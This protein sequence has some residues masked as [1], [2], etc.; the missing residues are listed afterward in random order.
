TP[1]PAA[2]AGPGRRRRGRALLAAATAAALALGL[3]AYL[4]LGP[5][6]DGGNRERRTA[7]PSGTARW[8]SPPEGWRPWQ[9]TLRAPAARGVVKAR[10]FGL[11]GAGAAAQCLPSGGAVYCG[12]EAALPVRLDASTGATDWRADL[13][14]PGTAAG[15]YDSA[16]LG[17]RDGV[18]VV[19]QSRYDRDMN[20]EDSS[21]VALDEATGRTVWSRPAVGDHIEAVFSSGVVLVPGKG[22]T[23]TAVSPRTGAERWTAELPAGQFCSFP[24]TEEGL[25]VEC[26]PDEEDA[27]ESPLLV[28]DPADGSVR[29]LRTPVASGLFGT[30]DGRLLLLTAD[31]GDTGDAF[32]EILL[33]DPDSGARERI[34]PAAGELRGTG[35]LRDGTLWFTTPDGVVTAVSPR[36]GAVRWQTRTTLEQP[37]AAAPDPRTRTVYLASPTGRVAALDAREGTVL[38]ETHPRSEGAALG[39]VTGSA[40]LPHRGAL[41]VTTPDGTVFGMDPG[42]PGRKPVPG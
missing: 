32:T 25:Y 7:G 39:G 2:G 38:W 3:T 26:V 28:L 31:E 18:V 30:V 19:R 24:E 13:V 16:V 6:S 20:L 8:G 21:V 12:G 33:V 40:V 1:A 10:G 27:T 23:L 29:R 41:I 42:H 34:E 22:R 9:T 37:G 5:D 11:D 36:T 17:V 14:P 15:S 4:V 35:T